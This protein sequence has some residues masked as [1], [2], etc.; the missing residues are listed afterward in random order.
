MML[1]SKTSACILPRWPPRSPDEAEAGV[2]EDIE[3][4][5]G[6][7]RQRDGLFGRA[8]LGHIERSRPSR[9]GEGIGYIVDFH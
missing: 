4:A 1:V 5:E 3:P 8:V 2:D 7:I 9:F 6:V